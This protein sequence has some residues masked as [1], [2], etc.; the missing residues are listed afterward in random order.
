MAT[1]PEEKTRSAASTQQ[2][3][4]GLVLPGGGARAAYQVGVLKAIGRL[5]PRG[6]SCPFP[7]L[8]GTSA[9]AINA[10]LLAAGFTIAQTRKALYALDFN[11]FKDDSW[12]VLRVPSYIYTLI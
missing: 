9:G 6:R 4:T 10:V 2:L 7:I 8:T 12:G 5:L 3:A 11:D 1:Q